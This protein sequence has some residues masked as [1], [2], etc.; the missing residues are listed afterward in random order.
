MSFIA[1][2]G[3]PS[4]LRLLQ[5]A[6]VFNEVSYTFSVICF[7]LSFFVSIYSFIHFI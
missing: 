6:A 5:T 4:A 7:I 3:K 2:S 1:F